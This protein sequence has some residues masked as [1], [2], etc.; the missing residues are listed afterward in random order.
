MNPRV[1][2]TTIRGRSFS[3]SGRARFASTLLVCCGLALLLPASAPA[4][5]GGGSAGTSVC[6]GSPEPSRDHQWTKSAGLT[7]P[8][9]CDDDDDDDDGDDDSSGGSGQAIAASQRTPA[10]HNDQSHIV[11]VERDAH[12]CRPLDAHSLRGPPAGQKE[13]SD[14]DVDDDDDDDDSVG[15][16]HSALQAAADRAPRSLSSLDTFHPPSTGSD[17][18]LRAPPR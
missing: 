11:H 2:S 5:R 1:L 8:D 15:A 6:A 17:Q 14:A 3:E 13:S 7:A 10:N 9:S 4:E 12:T 16:Q 18:A